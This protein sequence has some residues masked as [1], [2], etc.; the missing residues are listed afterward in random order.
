MTHYP[1][2]FECQSM[3]YRRHPLALYAT[4]MTQKDN[5]ILDLMSLKIHRM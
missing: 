1:P 3:K 4:G 2:L 5:L